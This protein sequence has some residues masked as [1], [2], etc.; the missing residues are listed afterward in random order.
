MA[1]SLVLWLLVKLG[2]AVMKKKSD[3][4]GAF[5]LQGKLLAFCQRNDFGPVLGERPRIVPVFTGCL[6]VPLPNIECGTVTRSTTT[7]AIWLPA[8]PLDESGRLRSVPGSSGRAQLRTVTIPF[9]HRARTSPFTTR[10][11]VYENKTS[12]IV[13]CFERG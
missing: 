2:M 11:R 6:L 9:G 1:Q 8:T 5:T 4:R 12:Y 10:D 7:C 3:F 13:R